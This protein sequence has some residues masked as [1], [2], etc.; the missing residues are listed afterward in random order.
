MKLTHARLILFFPFILFF[1]RQDRQ[2]AVSKRIKKPAFEGD[3]HRS[4]SSSSY[5]SESSAPV[6]H[7]ARLTTTIQQA[8]QGGRRHEMDGDEQNQSISVE[9]EQVMVYCS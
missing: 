4:S 1:I 8:F 3:N 2:D 9:Q 7:D 6:S 5:S